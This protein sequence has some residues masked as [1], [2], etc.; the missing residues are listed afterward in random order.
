MSGINPGIIGWLK[1]SFIDYPGMV[2]SVLFFS[3][4][5]LRCPYCHNPLIVENKLPLVSFDEIKGYL[6]KRRAIIDGVVLSG[7]EPTIHES[8]LFVAETLRN[9]NF[10][11]KLDTNG[12]NPDMI[13]K[14]N[15]DYL[16]VD[17][18]TSFDRYHKLSC[19]KKDYRERLTDTLEI[20]KKMGSQAEVRITAA[21]GLVDEYA[22][23]DI[24]EN[25]KG[26]SNIYLQKFNPRV[27]L[28]DSSY[29]D[30]EPIPP[31]TL[32]KYCDYISSV[33]GVCKIRGE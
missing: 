6:A 3:G 2:S 31:E 10:S 29:C 24:A 1:N 19:N 8:L 5:N 32:R 23:K 7:G 25:L 26:V 20:V 22:V 16:A 33:T 13:L 14:C 9:D 21:P 11:I 4:C 12:L 17:I 28:L 15:P 18:K 30:L 27:E